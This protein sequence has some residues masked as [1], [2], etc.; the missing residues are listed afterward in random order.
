MLKN[1]GKLLFSFM[2]T[3]WVYAES[4][5]LFP[6]VEQLGNRFVQVFRIPTHDEWG[7]IADPAAARRLSTEIDLALSSV[8]GS[9]VQNFFYRYIGKFIGTDQSQAQNMAR[10]KSRG[11]SDFGSSNFTVISDSGPQFFTDLTWF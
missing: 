1:F 10:Q 9:G 4:V 6:P 3:G 11:W 2:L 8:G 5:L 7:E